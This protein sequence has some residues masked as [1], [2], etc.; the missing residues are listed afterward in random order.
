MRASSGLR[1]SGGAGKPG[2]ALLPDLANGIPGLGAGLGLGLPAGETL[3]ARSGEATNERDRCREIA[4]AHRLLGT[5]KMGGIIR[6]G[7]LACATHFHKRGRTLPQAG[8]EIGLRPIAHLGARLG[9]VAQLIAEACERGWRV[10]RIGRSGASR[11]AAT[12]KAFSASIGPP[13]ASLRWKLSARFW[14][15]TAEAEARA[16]S[17]LA[18]ATAFA[19]VVTWSLR[20]ATRET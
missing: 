6:A 4:T 16:S 17:P 9:Q 3:G 2:E 20:P 19:S 18:E 7:D 10:L 1:R 14:L 5:R 11:S 15:T 12:P 13:K 8:E